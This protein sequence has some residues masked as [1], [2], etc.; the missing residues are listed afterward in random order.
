MPLTYPESPPVI[1]DF[2]R[3]PND[4]PL[5]ADVCIIG[6][7]AAGITLA[8]EL[9][10]SRHRVLLVES[11]GERYEEAVQRLCETE[12]ADDLIRHSLRDG[13][14]M[15]FGGTTILWAGQVMPLDEIDFERRDWVPASG[16]PFERATLDP[17]Y[18][19]AE[20]VLGLEPISYGAESWPSTS[21]RP[22]TFDPSK[23]D[24]RYSRFS[25]TPDL[26]RAHRATLAGTTT[27]TVM[28]HARAVRLETSPDGSGIDRV[29]LRSLSGQRA[30][31]TAHH[32]VLCCGAIE[33]ARLLL[34]SGVGDELVG[35]Y[36]Q[37][38]AHVKLRMEPA[39]RRAFQAMFNTRRTRGARYYPKLAASREFQRQHKILN[40]G[41]DV[42]YD[43]DPNSGVESAKLLV[44]S[45]R[46]PD[47]RAQIP[48]AAWNFATTPHELLAAAY[49]HLVLKQKL[50]EGR[51][52]ISFSVQCEDL[53][54]P[55]NR[56]VLSTGTD[57]LGVPRA[58]VRWR[59]SELAR[60]SIEL[61]A[62]TLA[63]ELGR[64][65]LGEIDLSPFPLPD[66]PALV[67][68]FVAP[69]FHH[70]GTTRMHDDPACGVVDRHCRVHG[71]RNLYVGSSSVFPAAG[72]SNP[73]LT[74]M[75]LCVRLADRLRAELG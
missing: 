62:G 37:E 36:F 14:A 40:V 22:P 12:S 71:T 44:R 52:P 32:Y 13:R 23:L 53:P 8:L 26:A 64:H 51:G 43:L 29:E 41:G 21:R 45:L 16:W 28:L 70:V 38:H 9:I 19:R 57:A 10:G 31:A 17:Y 59:L 47:L 4:S 63:E 67:S 60:R 72:Y 15:V 35:R 46:R 61:F 18:R 25:P 27:I 50:S 54:D 33:T 30:V 20:R 68:T 34:A 42:C 73:T 24:F 49:R 2:D 65:R 56:V 5:D 11:G 48:M 66:D 6:A 75:A 74:I 55:E 39:N 1:L 3:L 69:G 58:L 7:G